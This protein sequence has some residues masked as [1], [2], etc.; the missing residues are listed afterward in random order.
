M[1]ERSRKQDNQSLVRDKDTRCKRWEKEKQNEMDI[2]TY[3][4][5]NRARTAGGEQGYSSDGPGNIVR[6]R[7]NERRFP[8]RWPL[9]ASNT[10]LGQN[11]VRLLP[12]IQN[13]RNLIASKREREGERMKGGKDEGRAGKKDFSSSWKPRLTGSSH[14]TRLKYHSPECGATSWLPLNGILTTNLN[15]CFSV[16]VFHVYIELVLLLF[17][18][19]G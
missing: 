9:R 1:I 8:E 2:C 19:G 6:Q 18:E 7:R 16:H 12:R 5:C 14:G 17:K 4:G 3:T 10:N 11:Y 15:R 13:N